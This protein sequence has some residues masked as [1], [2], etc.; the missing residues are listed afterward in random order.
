MTGMV[1]CKVTTY[2]NKLRYVEF[3]WDGS[4][5]CRVSQQLIDICD[6]AYAKFGG[7]RGYIGP[8]KLNYLHTDREKLWQLFY[9]DPDSLYNRIIPKVYPL[10]VRWIEF[11]RWIGPQ[12]H[13]WLGSM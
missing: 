12:F 6:P 13:N 11:W 5:Y 4:N 8:F 7:L 3:S 1:I 2:P 10:Y 9:H